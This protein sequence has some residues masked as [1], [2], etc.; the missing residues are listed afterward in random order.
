[1]EEHKEHV[2]IVSWPKEPAHLE[3]QFKKGSPAE[4][5]IRFEKDPA[6]VAI[7][8]WPR[9]PMNVDMNMLLSVRQPV[10]VCIRLC[11]PIC[12]KSDY[13]ISVNFLDRPIGSIFIKGMTKLFPC[14][15][16]ERPNPLCVDF[17]ELKEGTVIRDSITQYGV[18]FSPVERDLKVVTHGEPEGVNKMIF[19]QEGV[20]IEFP[21]PVDKAWLRISSAS[22][23][24]FHISVYAGSELLKTEDVT[25]EQ[26]DVKVEVA[27]DDMTALVISGGKGIAALI[28]VC[29]I[30]F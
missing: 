27:Q 13:T 1:M 15:E 24:P 16:S 18:K 4:V 26:G 23:Q 21:Y 8:H 22:P 30:A 29:Y 25:V 12:A 17:R 11:E 3:H 6:N 7:Q 19:P 28:E 9:D 5:Q 14:F 10:P 20:R 2:Y